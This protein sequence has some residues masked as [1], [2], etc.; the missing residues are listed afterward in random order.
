MAIPPFRPLRIKPSSISKSPSAPH[1]ASERATSN[2]NPKYVNAPTLC[3]IIT[4]CGLSQ[5]QSK[6]TRGTSPLDTLR[7]TLITT[8]ITLKHFN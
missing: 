1:P 8:L 6:T 5:S 4:R 2:K 7:H 3:A